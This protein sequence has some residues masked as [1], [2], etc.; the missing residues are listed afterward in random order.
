MKLVV[1]EAHCI[2]PLVL[3]VLMQMLGIV[4]AN[5]SV[6]VTSAAASSTGPEHGWSVTGLL[7][8]GHCSTDTAR[9]RRHHQLVCKLSATC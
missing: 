6:V 1:N 2:M 3:Y 5:Q 8:G 4:A 9:Q 7:L